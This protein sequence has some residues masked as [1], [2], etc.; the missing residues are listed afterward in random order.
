MSECIPV[1]TA[2]QRGTGQVSCSPPPHRERPAR[3]DRSRQAH[4]GPAHT[5]IVIAPPPQTV[6]PRHCCGRA[7]R[8]H[9]G[10][11]LHDP[12]RGI[13]GLGTSFPVVWPSLGVA[14]IVS[15]GACSASRPPRDVRHHRHALPLQHCCC[16]GRP[17][18][19]DAD[20]CGRALS[21]PLCAPDVGGLFSF[22]A[23]VVRPIER[24]PTSYLFM[25][26]SSSL[27]AF[28]FFPSSK[29]SFSL[30]L[31]LSLSPRSRT[32]A[33]RRLPESSL[34]A[35]FHASLFPACCFPRH[36]LSTL[37]RPRLSKLKER[38]TTIST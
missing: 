4:P 3:H 12:A 9:Q 11:D 21:V 27:L 37:Q 17:R 29:W 14:V 23:M 31:S 33:Y 5:Y 6:V 7:R 19:Q 22:S 1:V 13:L 38:N 18:L 32:D 35:F 8:R 16:R 24:P 2:M 26:L 28:S 10:A 30:S 15:A 34:C 25:C 36:R 20:F